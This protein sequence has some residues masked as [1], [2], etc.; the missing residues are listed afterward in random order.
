MEEKKPIT[1]EQLREIAGGRDVDRF[2]E[3]YRGIGAA[4]EL[5]NEAY[6]TNTCPICGEKISSESDSCT[7]NEA[8]AH[9]ALT[10][11]EE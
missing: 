7:A 11:G 3:V 6:E 5:V 10:H 4:L 9:L 1:E 2:F 8:L